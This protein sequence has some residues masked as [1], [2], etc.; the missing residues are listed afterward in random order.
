MAEHGGW[1]ELLERTGALLSGHFELSSGLH[2]PTYV[3]CARALEDPVDA[4]AL[5]RGI[6]GSFADHEVDRVIAPPLGALLIGYE[7]ARA[8][9]VAFTFPER[10]A[11]G[12]LLL[13]RGFSIA[14]GERILVVEDVIT[15]GRTTHEVLELVA[16][17][18]AKVAGV[19]AIVDRSSE[20]V[21]D[22]HPICALLR[23]EIPT[24]DPASCPLCREGIPLHK[25]GSR[26]S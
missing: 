7:V 25:P 19:A 11:E 14:E 24:F 4:E 8:L 6:A 26:T 2:S 13:R 22:G 3:Q 10:D 1:E 12:R 20:H 17:C 5:A 16:A 18:G 9:G 15:T 23:L 21:L